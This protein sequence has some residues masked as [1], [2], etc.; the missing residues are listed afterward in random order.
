M[1]PLQMR[2]VL[3][4]GRA[5]DLWPKTAALSVLLAMAVPGLV[6]LAMG[7]VDLMVYTVG[8]ST[9]ALYGHNLPYAARARA[10][11]CV[12]L[13]MAASNG[14]GLA[15]AAA[16]SST[17]IRVAVAAL[18]AAALKLVCET[19]RIGPPGNVIFTF[20][21]AGCAFFPQR[22]TDIPATSRSP[23]PRRCS[24]GWCA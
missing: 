19:P 13:G 6:L 24:P 8:G 21:A 7:R 18:L 16:T 4:L 3:R 11:A 17:A 1:W 23:L 14:V 5:T 22:L 2:G 15:T 9:C 10:L 12:V 20:V